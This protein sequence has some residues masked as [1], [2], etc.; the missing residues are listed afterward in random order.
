MEQAKDHTDQ[1]ISV[2]VNND[3]INQIL[4]RSLYIIEQK[5]EVMKETLA[6]MKVN[7]SDTSCS[8]SKYLTQ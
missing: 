2:T 6:T 8:Q 4:K 1:F 3:E 5:T 7:E